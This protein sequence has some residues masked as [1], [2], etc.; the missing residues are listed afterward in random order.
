MGGGIC[1]AQLRAGQEG[2]LLTEVICELERVGGTPGGLDE[3]NSHFAA[4]AQTDRDSPSFQRTW[5]T[6]W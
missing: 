3:S 1:W 5:C 2:G 4:E 6:P